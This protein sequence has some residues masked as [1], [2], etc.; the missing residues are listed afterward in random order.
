MKEAQR[1]ADEFK[2][3]I[4]K[5]INRKIMRLYHHLMGI[6]ELKRDN[7]FQAIDN[8]KKA[9]TL[10]PS[11][12]DDHA[13]FIDYLALAYYK[14]GY[15]EKAQ[16]EYERIISLTTC[17]LYYGDIYAQSLY[18]LGRIYQE[19]GW[20]GKAIEHDDKFL[21]LWKDADPGI[22]KLIDAQKRQAA[23]QRLLK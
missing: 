22:P 7:F 23:L 12:S 4:Q 18:I 13:L 20:V 14:A 11:Q 9:V 5:G 21:H 15:I 2:E 19:K 16:E 3:L 6:I 10:L 8:F 1:A 17:R